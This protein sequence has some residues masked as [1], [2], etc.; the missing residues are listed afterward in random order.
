L[1]H[2]RPHRSAGGHPRVAATALMVGIV[3]LL[4]AVALFG[5]FVR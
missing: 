3:V 2:S 5:S 1:P 4:V